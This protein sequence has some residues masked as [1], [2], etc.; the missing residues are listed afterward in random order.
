MN[1]F[2]WTCMDTSS[3]NRSRWRLT[4]SSPAQVDY[5]S[6]SHPYVTVHFI[7]ECGAKLEARALSI[8]TAARHT[9]VQY[10]IQFL[11]EMYLFL[12]LQVHPT[13]P[14][15]FCETDSVFLRADT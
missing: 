11:K 2:N 5:L 9:T 12:T 6:S 10:I 8:S 14:S 15:V 13:L 7:M 1:Y 3:V 4:P